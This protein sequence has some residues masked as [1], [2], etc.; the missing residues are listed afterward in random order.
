MPISPVGWVVTTVTDPVTWAEAVIWDHAT[1]AWTADAEAVI[2]DHDA[3]AW[4]TT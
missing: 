3:S 2:W 1:Q 4:V